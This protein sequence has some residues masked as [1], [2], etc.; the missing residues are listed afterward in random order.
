[1]GARRCWFFR[2]W[3]DFEEFLDG[4][5][6]VSTRSSGGLFSV[7]LR[8]GGGADL[9]WRD[10]EVEGYVGDEGGEPDERKP[11]RKLWSLDGKLLAVESRMR[12]TNMKLSLF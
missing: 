7:V 11:G 10:E 6:T 2:P 3:R 9:R 5:P 8:T 1:M 12:D 4:V